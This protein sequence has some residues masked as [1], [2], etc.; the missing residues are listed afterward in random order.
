M[1]MRLLFLPLLVGVVVP[2]LSAAEA[3]PVR[4]LTFNIRYAN[5]DDG[6]DQW[7]NR[8]DT[9]AAIIN[10]EAD[11]VATQEALPVQIA[12]LTERLKEFT[13]VSRTRE[14]SEKEGEACAVFF[15]KDRFEATASGTFWLSDTPDVPGSKSWGNKLPRICT[16]IVL[17]E[18]ATGRELRVFA[19]HLD[20]QSEE[21][22]K[23]GA[24]LVADRAAAVPGTT[25]VL[26]DFNA[27]WGDPATTA[28]AESAGWKEAWRTAGK[29]EGGT[30]NGWRDQGPFIHIDYIFVREGKIRAARILREKTPA[31]RQASDHFPLW[32]EME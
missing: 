4:F 11:I 32:M 26:G 30:F 27:R 28:F 22:K 23:M 12:D 2:S 16:W 31:G 18:K 9:V 10:R 7:E 19:T 14:V 15:R 29:G 13:V 5:K 20:H 3:Q 1:D 17:K 25:I 24:A 21:A 6:P 8:R